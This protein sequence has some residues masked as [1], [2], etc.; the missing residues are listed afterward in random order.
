MVAKDKIQLTREWILAMLYGK[1]QT[2]G[3]LIDIGCR[4]MVYGWEYDK[5]MEIL[6]SMVQEGYIYESHTTWQYSVTEK[7]RFTI[8]KHALLPLEQ[9]IENPDLLKRFVEANKEKCDTQFLIELSK[10][11]NKTSRLTL[12]KK[13][14]E[15]NYENIAKIVSIFLDTYSR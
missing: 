5:F 8:R 12:I 2:S 9:L 1:D 14:A 7:G 3:D 13:Y 15:Q 10:A 6:Q 11:E 4:V